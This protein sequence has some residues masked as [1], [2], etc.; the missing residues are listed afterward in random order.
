MVISE[1][2]VGDIFLFPKTGK[3]IQIDAMQKGIIF[4]S[5]ETGKKL[6]TR[7]HIW[8]FAQKL[9]DP[10][11]IE[12]FRRNAALGR[13]LGAAERSAISKMLNPYISSEEREEAAGILGQTR[14]QQKHLAS[15]ISLECAG[16]TVKRE[17]L[18]DIIK[19]AEQKRNGSVPG[20]HH[21]KDQHSR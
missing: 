4:Y 6:A 15:R 3:R 11:A 14:N 1:A 12:A 7:E 21:T 18:S 16:R 17:S 9:M 10:A 2:N 8:D 19:T 5:T 20:K 13:C